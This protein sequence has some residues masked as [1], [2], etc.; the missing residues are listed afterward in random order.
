MVSP[1][2]AFRYGFQFM[3]AISADN[4]MGCACRQFAVEK[5]RRGA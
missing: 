1:R 4:V 5:S 3:D 2:N